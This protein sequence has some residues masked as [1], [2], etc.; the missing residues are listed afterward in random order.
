MSDQQE[1]AT[2]PIEPSPMAVAQPLDT[3]LSILSLAISK[4]C[5]PDALDKLLAL[6]ERW[7]A[8]Q[9]RK[10]FA[11]SMHSCQQE[12]PR[13]LRDK[14][15]SQ[16]R[17]RYA[18]LERVQERSQ[19]IYSA[20][21][22]SLSYG[23]ADCIRE[24]WKRTVCDVRHVGGHCERYHLD[25]PLDGF[26]AKGTAIGAMNPVQAA[27]ST[28]SYGQRRLLCMIFNITLT[29]EDNDGQPQ[30][31]PPAAKE[32][33]PKTQPRNNRAPQAAFDDLK[34]VWASRRDDLGL[35]KSGELFARW[36]FERQLLAEKDALAVASW[37]PEMITEA[38]R[39]IN[40]EMPEG[41]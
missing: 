9:A 27:I 35:E 30:Y 41:K 18:T 32:D 33:A 10:L 36:A 1:L 25:L 6:Q 5:D 19:P 20:H 12:M 4:G 40:Q 29:N 26:S 15:N 16:T 34:R 13:I 2:L 38:R 37:T 22:F 17:S 11:E 21:G 3:P 14:E 8:N 39:L 28:T 23:E 7:E 31:E 24:G